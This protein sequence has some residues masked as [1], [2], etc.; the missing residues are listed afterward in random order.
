MVYS[1]REIEDS[2]IQIASLALLIIFLLYV[3]LGALLLPALN[4]EVREREGEVKG[5]SVPSVRVLSHWSE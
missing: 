2:P 3:A 4:G 5:R 1:G